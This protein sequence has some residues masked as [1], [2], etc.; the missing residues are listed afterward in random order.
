[1]G[2]CRMGRDPSASVVDEHGRS[3]DIGNLF[4]CDT[5]V[6]VT[7]G[8]VNSTLTAMALASRAAD[9]MADAARRGDL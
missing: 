7:G 9:H 3:H 5:S 8:G 2:T 4:V 1:M 6:F